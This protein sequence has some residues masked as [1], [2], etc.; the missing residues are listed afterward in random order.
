[1]AMQGYLESLYL[2]DGYLSGHVQ[3][4][5]GVQIQKNI[6]DLIFDLGS[7]VDLEIQDSNSVFA[8]VE[9]KINSKIDLGSQV[10]KSILD[11]EKYNNNQ[12]NLKINHEL[13]NGIQSKLSILDDYVLSTQVD[14]EI[15]GYN[16]VSAQIERFIE[17]R[18]FN[19]STQVDLE[20]RDSLSIGMQAELKLIYLNTVSTQI[21]RFIEDLSVPFGV[22]VVRGSLLH[23]PCPRYLMVP[24]LTDKYLAECFTTPMGCSTYLTVK[25]RPHVGS[26]I[27]KKIYFQD[28]MSTQ[29][30]L[31]THNVEEV[32]VQIDLEKRTDIKVS[33]QVEKVIDYAK[34]NAVQIESKIYHD[35]SLGTQIRRHII[36]SYDDLYLPVQVD[37]KINVF[38]LNL[39]Q[40]LKIINVQG[41]LGVQVLRIGELSNKVQITKALYN[42]TQLRI[43]TDFASRGVPSQNGETWTSDV[44]L[45]IAEGDYDPNNLNTDILEQITKTAQG[46]RTFSILCDTGKLNTYVDTIAILNHNFTKGCTLEIYGYTSDPSGAADITIVPTVELENTYWISPEI[47]RIPYR[48]WRIVVNDYG[49]PY[50][51]Y[52]GVVVI[53]SSRIVSLAECFDNPVTFGFRHFKDTIETE[54]F[55]PVSNDRA[56]RKNLSLSFSM[57]KYNGGNYKWLRD[58]FI[59]NKTDLKALVIPR[60]TNPSSLA[61]FSKLSS[62]PSESHTAITDDEHYVTFTLDYDESL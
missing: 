28:P 10:L 1:M 33:S 50:A 38:M 53:G 47:P 36:S 16:S 31:R 52:M 19:L 8:Q 40:I 7:Q 9:S 59:T 56:I 48:Y 55:S 18:I 58:Y 42:T 17:D 25:N 57:L 24:Y 39:N 61:V 11:Y 4:Y 22:E 45:G 15:V 44:P 32:S 30:E 2:T 14:K 35:K 60:P 29:V 6:A 51:L 26:Q 34:I 37:L 41:H 62:L 12:V 21:E 13:S 23:I 49:N 3:E 5:L 27:H 20:I 43:L 54:G 46:I